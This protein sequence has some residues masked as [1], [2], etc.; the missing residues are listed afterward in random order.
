MSVAERRRRFWGSGVEYVF[1]DGNWL[2]GIRS[3][4][5]PEV[6]A[7]AGKIF[8]NSE[9]EIYERARGAGGAESPFLNSANQDSST[10]VSSGSPISRR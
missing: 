1:L 8:E 3:G 9:V 2:N 7:G 5:A 6:L 4:A 10:A